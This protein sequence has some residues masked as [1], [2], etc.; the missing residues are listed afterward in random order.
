MIHDEDVQPVETSL[1]STLFIS[2]NGNMYRFYHDTETWEIVMP[3]CNDNGKT[4]GYKNKSLERLIAEAWLPKPEYK[5]KTGRMPNV[6]VKD[7]SKS[8]LDADNLEWCIGRR[9]VSCDNIQVGLPYKLELLKDLLENETL[10]TLEEFSEHLFVSIPT[11]RNY[12]CK[13]MSY[14]PTL[15]IA[16]KIVSFTNQSCLTYCLDKNLEGPLRE[17]VEKIESYLGADT[18]EDEDCKFFDVRVCRM[19]CDILSTM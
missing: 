4:C 17:L 2:K 19:Y 5:T 8:S 14:K 12:M 6:R 18:W 11:V 13:L 16:E 1:R 9:C 15:E 10:E 7:E 3:R